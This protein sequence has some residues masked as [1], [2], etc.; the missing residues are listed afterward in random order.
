MLEDK[1]DNNKAHN[2]RQEIMAKLSMSKAFTV[3]QQ[4]KQ[5]DKM[6][7]EQAIELVKD[8]FVHLAYREETYN[9]ILKS[10]ITG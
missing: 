5:A 10:T 1:P 3:S 7:K 8:L 4:L 9:S 2:D 6:N